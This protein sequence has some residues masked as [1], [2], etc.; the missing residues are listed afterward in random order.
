MLQREEG[1]RER[2]KKRDRDRLSRGCSERER[3]RQ[4]R[5]LEGREG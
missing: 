3:M 5:R 1:G 2:D 4:G